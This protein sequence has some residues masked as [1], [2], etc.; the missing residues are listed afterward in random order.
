LP[1]VVKELDPSLIFANSGV[2]AIADRIDGVLSGA[3]SLPTERQCLDYA[4]RF[5]WPVIARRVR[6]VYLEAIQAR[7]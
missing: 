2:D 6:D 7:A 5:D 3:I 1:E 4:Q